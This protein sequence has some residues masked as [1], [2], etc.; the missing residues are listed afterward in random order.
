MKLLAQIQVG[1]N[2]IES[3]T[4]SMSAEAPSLDKLDQI[5][6]QLKEASLQRSVQAHQQTDSVRYLNELNS[7]LEAF[8]SGGTAQIQVVAAGV[9]KLCQQ[10]GCSGEKGHNVLAEIRQ[11][12]VD[13]QAIN[14]QTALLQASI[15]NLATLISSGSPGFNPQS[16]AGLIDQQRQEQEDLLRAVAAELTNEI[17]GER[18]RFVDAMK[19]ATAINVQMHVEE[20]KKELAHQVRADLLTYYANQKQPGP[21]PTRMAYSTGPAPR[22]LRMPNPGYGAYA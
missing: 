14:D 9:E 4:S 12:I 21:P 7:W 19:E 8:V 11:L 17:R 2:D 15:D 10:L 22:A 13:S 6:E 1:Q 5:L 20:L 18:L 3:K 16:F